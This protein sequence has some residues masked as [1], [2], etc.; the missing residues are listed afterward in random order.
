MIPKQ[1]KRL[2]IHVELLAALPVGIGLGA[3]QERLGEDGTRDVAEPVG[4]HHLRNVRPF[5]E[6]ELL[7]R[8]PDAVSPAEDQ[9]LREQRAEGVLDERLRDGELGRI[10]NAVRP[11]LLESCARVAVDIAVERPRPVLG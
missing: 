3:L 7:V 8:I 1:G 5:R 6:R 4:R 10:G 11:R 2:R 9:V